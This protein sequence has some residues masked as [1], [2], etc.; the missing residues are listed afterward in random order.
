[1]GQI[2]SLVSQKAR[3]S[4]YF[5]LNVISLCFS[6]TNFSHRREQRH[7]DTDKFPFNQDFVLNSLHC[8]LQM[9]S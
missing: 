3:I 4:D 6:V 1:M 9:A 7:F 8:V 2:L 5:L